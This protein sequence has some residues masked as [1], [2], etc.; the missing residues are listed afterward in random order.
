MLGQDQAWA[1][2]QGSDDVVRPRWE[3]AEGIGKLTRNTLR[4]HRKKT[5]RLTARMSEAVELAGVEEVGSRCEQELDH[6]VVS[7][8]GEGAGEDEVGGSEDKKPKRRKR[9][10]ETTACLLLTWSTH[11]HLR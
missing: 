8:G 9:D 4:D 11:I 5:I 7:M 1:S 10:Q 6:H 3:F 2:G